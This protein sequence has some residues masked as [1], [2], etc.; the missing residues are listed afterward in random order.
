LSRRT[1]I[2]ALLLLGFASV[3]SAE[4]HAASLRIEPGPV[5]LDGEPVGIAAEG[6]RA[7]EEVTLRSRR[8]YAPLSTTKSAPKH[9]GAEIRIR[10]DADGRIDLDAM[11]PLAG[12]YAGVDPRGLF[13]SMVVIADAPAPA[14]GVDTSEVRLSLVRAAGDPIEAS[15]RLLPAHADVVVTRVDALPGAVFARL[16]GTQRPPA[17]ILLGGSEGGSLINTAAAPF[18][19]HGFAV[20]TV[21]YYSPAGEDGKRELP[22]LPEAMADH[23]V[24]SLDRAHAWLARRDDVDATRV[25]VHG[26]SVGATFAL[27]AAVHL[28]WVDAVVANV[29]SDVV[30]DGWG[31][32]IA[33]GT[34]SMFSLRGESLPFVP[35]LGYGEEEAR[36]ARGL[37]AHVSRP[38]LRG[39]AA[40]PDLAVKA[41]IPVER[42]RGDVMVIG[43]FDDRMWPSGMMA[44]NIAERRAEAGKQTTLLNYTDAG[45]PLYDTGYAPTTTYNQR[46]KK[47]GGTP[48]SNARAQAEVWPKTIAFL[49]QSLGMDR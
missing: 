17:L 39:R 35:L 9:F 11:A 33:D 14:A 46:A 42:I 36:A 22:A 13:W 34:R 28:D 10:A 43:A 27:L 47:V 40:R 26:T 5:V 20:L 37:E 44:Q 1:R 29:P 49:R 4:A 19:S 23:P 6:L 41:R 32:G 3:A 2:T 16:P 7:N 48:E 25:A 8:W 24:E 38:H 18:A 12:S 21:P 15:V 30:Y 31:P 45:H